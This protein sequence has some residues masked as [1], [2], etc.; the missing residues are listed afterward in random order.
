MNTQISLRQP[1]FDLVGNTEEHRFSL[2]RSAVTEPC[3]SSLPLLTQS[4]MI[5]ALCAEEY[6]K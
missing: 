1:K 6:L 3:C 2:S 4:V 5:L